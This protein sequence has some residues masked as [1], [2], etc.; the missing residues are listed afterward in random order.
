MRD[1]N[2]HGRPLDSKSSASA[3]SANPG[4]AYISYYKKL[5]NAI[6]NVYNIEVCN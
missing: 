3:S 2:P 6:K 5:E 4:I 1:L